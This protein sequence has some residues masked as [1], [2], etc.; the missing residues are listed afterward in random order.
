VR[1]ERLR[2][3]SFRCYEQLACELAGGLT[4][5]VGPNGSGK[6]SLVEALHFGCLG[7]SP[8]TTD[9]S[10]VVRDGASVTRVE[11]A[12]VAAGAA[13]EVSLGFQPHMPKRIV[14]DGARQRSADVL[15]ERFALLVFTPDRLAVVKGAPAIRRAFLDRAV[16][17]LWPRFG[18]IAADYG[19]VLQQRNHLLRR[20]RSGASSRDSLAAWNAQLASL[21]GEVTAARIR[22]LDRLAEPFAAHLEALGGSPGPVALGYRPAGPVTDEEILLELERRASQD[23]DRAQ[24]GA[25]PHRDDFGFVERERD[26]RSFGSQGEQRTALLALLLAES[27][28]VFDVRGLRPVMLLDDVASELDAD[29]RGRLLR[30]VAERGQA[31]VTTTDEGHVAAAAQRVLHVEAGTVQAA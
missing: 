1:V 19:Q 15:A 27:D 29:R 2:A 13:F 24:T 17:R 4:A 18:R 6:T 5:V 30:A 20:I 23:V 22:L 28:L 12:G 31:V 16:A 8:R 26:V 3:S 11:V 10:R 21:G 25:G 14:L 7:W 9:E